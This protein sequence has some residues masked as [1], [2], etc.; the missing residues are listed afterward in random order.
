M[1]LHGTQNLHKKKTKTLKKELGQTDLEK[2]RKR[3]KRADIWLFFRL[4]PK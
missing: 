3:P 4:Y 2:F 1:C